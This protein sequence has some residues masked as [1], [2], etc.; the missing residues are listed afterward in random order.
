MGVQ[1]APNQMGSPQMG[2]QHAPTQR[3][4]QQQIMPHQQQ[5]PVHHQKGPQ[6]QQLHGH[7]QTPAHLQKEPLKKEPVPTP[8]P[9]PEPVKPKVN[10]PLCKTEL[11][12][13][14]SDPPN[15]NTCT[16]CHSQVC[17]LCGFNPTPHLVEVRTWLTVWSTHSTEDLH[18]HTQTFSHLLSN[19][20]CYSAATVGPPPLHCGC[21]KT[22]IVQTFLFSPFSQT[23]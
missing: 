10:C 9:A 1:H 15:Y 11:N 13:G 20:Q 6:G 16:Q 21:T 19:N 14:S 2:G 22:R 23:L 8:Q 5:S 17:N 3:Q 12:I 18:W 7:Q 4:Q